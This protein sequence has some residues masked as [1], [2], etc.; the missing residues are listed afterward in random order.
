M[1]TRMKANMKDPP[2]ILDDLQRAAVKEAIEEV[3]RHREYLLY[4]VNVRTNHF[5]VVTFAQEKPELMANTFK[6]YATREMRS[7]GLIGNETKVWARGR[8]RRYLW[9]ENHVSAAI[10]YV[11][12]SQGL[13]DFE[14]WYDAK[15]PSE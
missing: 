8:S 14:K 11:L 1:L 3:C 13:I 7:R 2:M 9:K 10:D 5:H 6:S 12:Y 4:G 15:Y